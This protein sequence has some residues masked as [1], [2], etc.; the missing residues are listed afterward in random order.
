MQF[1]NRLWEVQHH[2]RYIG[3]CLDIAAPL[4]LEDIALRSDDGACLE[5]F[6]N[7]TC[8]T[9]YCVLLF[10]NIDVW[11]YCNVVGAAFMPRIAGCDSAPVL[12]IGWETGG[13]NAAPT[14][15]RCLHAKRLG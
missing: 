15:F 13:M 14:T 7:T 8:C 11:R 12:R 1:F 5:S 4:K 10:S 3:T 9:H 2:L 6:Q